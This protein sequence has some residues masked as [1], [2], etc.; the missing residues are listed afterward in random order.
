MWVLIAVVLAPIGVVMVFNIVMAIIAFRVVI[1]QNRKKYFQGSEKHLKR[2]AVKT[3]I[4]VVWLVVLFGLGWIFGLLTIRQVSVVSKYI[5]VIING[6][7]G[8]YFFFFICLL[9]KEARDF[10]AHIITRGRFDIIKNTASHNKVYANSSDYKVRGGNYGGNIS[11]LPANCKTRK[12]KQLVDYLT[13]PSPSPIYD[14]ESFLSAND[15]VL[16]PSS[17]A[18]D[19][20]VELHDQTAGTIAESDSRLDV[21]TYFNTTA[22]EMERMGIVVDDD[23]SSQNEAGPL[24]PLTLLIENDGATFP[25]LSQNEFKHTENELEDVEEN[26]GADDATTAMEANQD[27]EMLVVVEEPIPPQRRKKTKLK[28]SKREEWISEE[29]ERDEQS[30]DH[31]CAPQRRKRKAATAIATTQSTKHELES[32]MQMEQSEHELLVG[33]DR[34]Q[35]WKRGVTISHQD[36]VSSFAEQRILRQKNVEDQVGDVTNNS[37]FQKEE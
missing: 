5:F 2:M 33:D 20:V 13:L 6:F 16:E 25:E 24:E 15:S 37:L 30:E 31:P 34:P 18:L 3:L 17:L 4:T 10:W 1:K 27:S 26:T 28:R 8:L 22:D 19:T 23:P 14:S 11:S 21:T 29:T 9:Q 7:Q 35:E 36:K 12:N 32:E